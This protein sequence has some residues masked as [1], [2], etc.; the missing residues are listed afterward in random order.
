MRS[1]LTGESGWALVIAMMIMAVMLTAGLGVFGFVDQQG[2]QSSTE[3]KRE[4]SLNLA[5]SVLGDQ[6][7]V[8][9]RN[10]PGRS[11]AAYPNC[12]SS[13]YVAGQAQQC[14]NPSSLAAGITAA[15]YT[16]G[17]TW[18]TTVRDNSGTSV[19]FYDDTSTQAQPAYDSNA[20]G[21]LWV[22]SRAVVRGQT[23]TVVALVQ[24]QQV[25]DAGIFPHN[26]ITAGKF[27]TSN[28][29]NKVI[30]D[31]KG[32]AAQASSL[33][34]RCARAS[35]SCLNYQAG[36]GQVSPDTTSD[37]Y[38]GGNALSAQRLDELRSRAKA[39]GT[40]YATGTCPSNWTAP[41]IFVENANCSGGDGNSEAA[42][43]ALVFANG[44]LSFGGNDTFYGLIYMANTSNSTGTV[45]ST[46]GTSA[47]YGSVAID[48]GGGVDAGSSK[49]NIIYDQNAY[50][51]LYG[52]G[53]A[54]VVQNTWR[55]L[56][57][58]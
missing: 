24:V 39:N 37:N 27:S 17:T 15:D 33:A 9:S 19:N 55:E 48:G 47:I 43:G 42:P 26:V 45:V 8:V 50:S 23:R 38:A 57:A 52:Y 36:K 12:S 16:T 13:A 56:L 4:S 28:H 31:T 14:P 3:R 41:L 32:N 22:R 35:P 2:K 18:T 53:S 30:V 25:D 58:K 6:I 44:T 54:G 46:G 1:R 5:E 11:A 20:D 10:W 34:V 51:A 21:K 7:Y 29:G 49:E 40:Y